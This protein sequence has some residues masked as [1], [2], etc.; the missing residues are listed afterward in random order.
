M[1][2]PHVG[3]S[4]ATVRST[5]GGYRAGLCCK[6]RFQ[7]TGPSGPSWPVRATC[8]GQIPGQGGHM[9]GP[10]S[11]ASKYGHSSVHVQTV[12]GVAAEGSFGR[13][14][15][16]PRMRVEVVFA[17]TKPMMMQLVKNSRIAAWAGP[18]FLCASPRSG[19]P[20]GSA[21]GATPSSTRGMH[22]SKTF[23][24]S[25]PPNTRLA[26]ARYRHAGRQP[27]FCHW[28][29]KGPAVIHGRPRRVDFCACSCPPRHGIRR[30]GLGSGRLLQQLAAAIGHPRPPAETCLSQ[31]LAH[32]TSCLLASTLAHLP[33][34]WQFFT[35]PSLQQHR[36]LAAEFCE[37][38]RSIG[39][40]AK[41]RCAAKPAAARAPQFAAAPKA[42][43]VPS[44]NSS[45]ASTSSDS[46]N[47]NNIASSRTTDQSSSLQ[48]MPPQPNSVPD[49]AAGTMH[50]KLH[51]SPL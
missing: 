30:M 6:S 2:G 18:L 50:G 31:T 10:T 25:S 9:S 37:G 20:N 51:V 17:Q 26:R 5:C 4:A 36:P 35:R 48:H 14:Q 16:G 22:C 47:S 43:P 3:P 21:S 39:A 32:E 19:S 11:A 15:P 8:P 12:R 27:W 40:R 34:A 1:S 29:Q 28:L 45:F 23:H 38:G 42:D 49:V 46:S 33:W 41:S 24:Q 13:V 7:K 44:S